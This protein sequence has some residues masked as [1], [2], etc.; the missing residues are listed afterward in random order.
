VATGNTRSLR[1]AEKA[2]AQREGFLRNRLLIQDKAHDAVM[3]SLIP[4]DL[5]NV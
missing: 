3:H 5:A 1:V 2:G 4:Q